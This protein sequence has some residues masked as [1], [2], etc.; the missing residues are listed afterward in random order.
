MTDTAGHTER[1]YRELVAAGVDP[2]ST[3]PRE[4][5]IACIVCR[6]P[7]FHQSGRC[8]SDYV[9]PAACDRAEVRA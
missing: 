2:Y 4:H 7:T 8:D 3:Q 5:A 9:R 1:D 6:R